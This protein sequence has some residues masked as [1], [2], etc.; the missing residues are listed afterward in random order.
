MKSAKLGMSITSLLVVS[1]LVLAACGDTPTATPVA[2]PT[3]TTAPA[4]AATNTTAPA[5]AATITVATSTDGGT[6]SLVSSL[7]RTGLS[8]TQTDDVV[9]GYK[10]AL[11]E[12]DNKAGGFDI[13]YEGLDD[14]YAQAGQ[15]DAATEQA[16]AT[17]AA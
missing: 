5:A 11:E 10:M 17:K 3:N 14:G 4:A 9:A 13:V 15:W 6:I 7:P 1:S 8:K 12:H 2:A 16:N